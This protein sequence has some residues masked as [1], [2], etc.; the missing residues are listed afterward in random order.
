M[1]VYTRENPFLLFPGTF[2]AFPPPPESCTNCFA[3]GIIRPMV[4]SSMHE[5]TARREGLVSDRCQFPPETRIREFQFVLCLTFNVNKNFC[6]SSGPCSLLFILLFFSCR[7]VAAAKVH[8]HF[9]SP[10]LDKRITAKPPCIRM[11]GTAV[12]PSSAGPTSHGIL[13]RMTTSIELTDVPGPTRS[14]FRFRAVAVGPCT[15]INLG[16]LIGPDLVPEWRMRWRCRDWPYQR[17]T[18]SAGYVDLFL[19]SFSPSDPWC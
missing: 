7:S 14:A 11:I 2:L 4:V 17:A 6:R 13:P 19:A 12:R 3:V 8:H 18:L 5:I 9:C 1:A 15:C 16:S 10:F